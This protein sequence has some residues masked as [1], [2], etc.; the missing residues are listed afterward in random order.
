MDYMG[1]R[2]AVVIFPS[3]VA[4]D[5]VERFRSQW[6]PLAAQIA[7]H[8]TLVFPFETNADPETLVSA[9]S[10]VARRHAPF[11]IELADPTV[12]DDEYL[13]LLA[14]QGGAQIR[15]LHLDLY[16]ALPYARLEGVFT[17]HMTVGRYRERADLETAALRARAIDLRVTATARKI[18][19]YRINGHASRSVE[20]IAALGT[21][22]DSPN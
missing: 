14:R 9:M 12:Y 17:P 3:D 2:R 18:S 13:F 20:F 11:A 7:A 8:V 19:L 6:D 1:V 4:T 15:R 16:A 5:A 22:N 10:D 21:P